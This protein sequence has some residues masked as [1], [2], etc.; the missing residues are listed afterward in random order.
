MVMV[1][2]RASIQDRHHIY[3]ACQGR[4]GSSR[5]GSD[6]VRAW[7]M[8]IVMMERVAG[9]L[10]GYHKAKSSDTGLILD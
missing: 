6:R 1:I 2:L 3:T 5:V 7:V 4:M 8:F 9:R 10:E